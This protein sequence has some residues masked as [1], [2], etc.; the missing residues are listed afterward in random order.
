M[1]VFWEKVGLLGP[2][3]GLVGQG[4]SDRDIAEKLNL[5]EVRVRDCVAWILHFLGF[6]YRTELVR[7]AAP[8]SARE[9][10]IVDAPLDLRI[11]ANLSL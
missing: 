1:R 5:N 2:I 10:A 7:Y 3:Y 6:T 9:A 4:F 11:A 8:P